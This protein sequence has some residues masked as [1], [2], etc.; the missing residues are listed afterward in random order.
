M[1]CKQVHFIPESDPSQA[2]F[3]VIK[4][5]FSAATSLERETLVSKQGSFA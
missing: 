4:V 1:L 2:S 3:F 5:A